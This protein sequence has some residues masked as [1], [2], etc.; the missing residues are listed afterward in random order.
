MDFVRT[1]YMGLALQCVHDV[2]PG[3]VAVRWSNLVPPSQTPI[4]TR[5]TREGMLLSFQC[6]SLCTSVELKLLLRTHPK[7]LSHQSYLRTRIQEHGLYEQANSRP[8]RRL[9]RLYP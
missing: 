8:S 5:W 4:R 9:R 1:N 3:G 2:I 7:L 6:F